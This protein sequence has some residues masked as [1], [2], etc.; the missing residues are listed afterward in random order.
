MKILIVSLLKRSITPTMTASR[1]R[2]IFELTKRLIAKG[3][4]VT[5]L[6]TG[7]SHVPGA[8][9][10][11]VIPKSFIELPAFENPFHAETAY[12]LLLAKKLE[13]LAPSYDIIHN[14][15]FPEAP[16]FLVAEKL[17]TPMVSTVHV[18]ATPE[19][20]D[21]L[22]AF[23]KTHLVSISGAHKKGFKKAPVT[24][25]IYNG[26]DTDLYAFEP[27]K[28]D[29]MLW[30]GRLSKA[31]NDDGSFMDPK[32]VKWAIALSEKTGV[33][34]KLSGNVEDREFFDTEVKT[35]LSDKIQWIGDVSGEQP[36]SKDEV[37][38]LMQKAKVFM[39][40]VNWD[41]P[42]GLVM[43]EAMSCG[44]PVIGFDRGAV[45]EVIKEGVTGFVVDPKEGVAGLA[46]ALKN[47]DS[48]DPKACRD[49]VLKHFSL[50]RMVGEYEKLYVDVVKKNAKGKRGR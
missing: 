17:T 50:E 26:I 28:E 43:A 18:Q 46:T 15:A 4:T 9:V 31:K 37:V 40:T 21:T 41:E 5:I 36:L 34:L 33:P 6:G 30:I 35:H 11:G 12:Y 16:V 44:T 47:I 3:H 29:Y 1:P 49:H 19:L 14:H 48:I 13:E 42:F 24:Q 22:A 38:K 7:D 27:K 39:M 10:I 32:G 2:M 45:S 20:D 23:K 25:V 8:D